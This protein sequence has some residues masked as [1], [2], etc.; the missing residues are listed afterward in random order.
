MQYN[1]PIGI[2]NC[3]MNGTTMCVAAIRKLWAKQKNGDAFPVHSIVDETTQDLPWYEIYVTDYRGN[4]YG[5]EVLTEKSQC[6]L[7]DFVIDERF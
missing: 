4:R 6:E 3:A 5:F 1:N 7:C 2:M